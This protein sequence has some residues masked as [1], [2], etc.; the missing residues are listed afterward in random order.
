MKKDTTV[1]S[2]RLTNDM[3][4]ELYQIAKAQNRNFSNLIETLLIE[5]LEEKYKIK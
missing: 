5:I 3:I 4:K 1:K 2:V